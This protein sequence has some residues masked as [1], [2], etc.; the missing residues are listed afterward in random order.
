[1]SSNTVRLAVIDD[2]MIIRRGFAE[3]VNERPPW[4]VVVEASNGLEYE[5]LAGAQ[6]PIH[7]ALVD[8]FM[9][10]R[11]GFDTIRWIRTH[12]PDTLP[13]ALTYDPT[14]LS[15]R[16][17]VV[18]GARGVL[19]KTIE[20]DALFAAI[21]EV[22]RTGYHYNELVSEELR[23]HL[24]ANPHELVHPKL[25]NLSVLELEFLL[26]YGNPERGEVSQIAQRMG[27]SST[28]VEDLRQR[29]AA[30]LGVQTKA[31]AAMLLELLG[32]R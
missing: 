19:P 18:A 1:M 9:P 8:L 14:E 31:Q 6:L 15:V 12:Q 23:T 13:I 27:M 3:L 32:Q 5:Q 21:E 10:E 24:M 11:N 7:V 28:S 16:R 2:H 25:A 29:I 20:P 4:Q 30:E 26:H 17:A 22:L